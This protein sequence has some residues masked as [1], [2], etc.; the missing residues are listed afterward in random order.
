MPRITSPL[1]VL[2]LLLSLLSRTV[3]HDGSNDRFPPATAAYHSYIA[4][5][6]TPTVQEA[7]Q[8]CR[9]KL[10]K[11]PDF[12]KAQ[13]M[14]AMLL[15]SIAVA[16]TDD[17]NLALLW[18]EIADLSWRAGTYTDENNESNKKLDDQKQAEALV[19][20][21]KAY[22]ELGRK[23]SRDESSSNRIVEAYRQALLLLQPSD[24]ELLLTQVTPLLMRQQDDSNSQLASSL[25]L[26]F[27]SSMLVLQFQGAVLRKAGNLT[28]S[29]EAYRRAAMV[30]LQQYATATNDDDD[31][32][33]LELLE[34]TVQSQILAASVG[35]EAGQSI[36]VQV[37]NLKAALFLLE[38]YNA[39]ETD[40]TTISHL[41]AEIYNSMGVAYKKAGNS[42][43]AAAI[44]AFQQ[45]LTAKP[46]DGHA[47]A[48]LASLNAL[49]ST[50]VET[51]D[52]EYVQGLFD[53]YSTRFEDELVQT[54]DYKGH[55]W[56]AE[57]LLEQL[58]S[59]SSDDDKSCSSQHVILDLGC[60]TGLVGS[61]L[62]TTTTL[63]SNDDENVPSMHLLGV[64]LSPRMVE[65]AQSRELS[66]ARVYNRVDV[67]DAVE[68]LQAMS[69]TLDAIVAADVFIYIGELMDV[70]TKAHRAL[71]ENG[72]VAFS[73]ELLVGDDEMKLLPSGR[74]GHSKS[75]VEKLAKDTG[76]SIEV[77]KEGALRKQR[78]EDVPGAVVVLRKN[79]QSAHGR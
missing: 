32:S 52:R 54:L 14:L 11:D 57:E 72:V 24:M 43:T 70:L 5:Q 17:S 67:G 20:A 58:R 40:A 38:K 59:K 19:R 41:Q 42:T 74:F 31:D 68:Y 18:Q 75:Y 51:L 69:S 29:H 78:G 44:D 77:W 8:K 60:G 21:A 64:D 46:N 55:E 62:R 6:S 25:L 3:T 50:K 22:T 12:A 45:A 15:E 79:R 63:Q 37:E 35:R 65:I 2:L 47:L 27:P 39:K 1:L 34:T 10:E 26:Y 61:H 66:G 33:L 49:S 7:I 73:V 53:G 76:F 30:A 4:T 56:V 13:H 48:Q 36:D 71:K 23:G 9:D 28:D 16:E